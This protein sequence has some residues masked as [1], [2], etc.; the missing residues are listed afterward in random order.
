MSFQKLGK[1]INSIITLI[2]SG[3]SVPLSKDLALV[4][5]RCEHDFRR[6][7]DLSDRP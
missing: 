4:P 1:I 5:G 6:D 3:G 2:R 7:E